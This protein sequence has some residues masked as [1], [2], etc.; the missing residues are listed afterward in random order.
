MR[1]G[2]GWPLLC[3]WCRSAWVLRAGPP[4]THFHVLVLGVR[5]ACGSPGAAEAQILFRAQAPVP[6]APR[7]VPPPQDPTSQGDTCGQVH[8]SRGFWASMERRQPPG[9]V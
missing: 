5:G 4:V 7:A 9:G 8:G 3:P 2:A 1:H 6:A